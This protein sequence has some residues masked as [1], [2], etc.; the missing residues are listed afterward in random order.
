MRRAAWDGGYYCAD[1]ATAV[2]WIPLTDTLRAWVAWCKRRSDA[3]IDDWRQ[4]GSTL[5]RPLR[6]AVARCLQ[7][8]DL[9][10]A[11]LHDEVDIWT[12]SIRDW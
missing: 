8:L 12:P 5:V 3:C 1:S 2:E 11:R 9:V 4:R 6:M 7:E 10:L